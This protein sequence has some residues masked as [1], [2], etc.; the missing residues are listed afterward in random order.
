MSS[1]HSSA[2]SEADVHQL[3]EQLPLQADETLYGDLYGYLLDTEGNPQAPCLLLLSLEGVRMA[4]S[5]TP[6]WIP[7]A[8]IEG[9]A[10]DTGLLKLVLPDDNVLFIGCETH[11]P[12]M[13]FAS[14]LLQA[15]RYHY[16]EA[17]AAL[18]HEA[19]ALMALG[20]VP[21]AATTFIRAAQADGFNGTPHLFAFLMNTHLGLGGLAA[22][23]LVEATLN[24]P[25]GILQ[26]LI[27]LW[28]LARFSK[29]HLLRME[30]SLGLDG[31]VDQ[32][33][34]PQLLLAALIAQRR[35]GSHA[36]LPLLQRALTLL[37]GDPISSLTVLEFG[38]TILPL[39]CLPELGTLSLKHL[40]D[41]RAI[42][43]DDETR[44]QLGLLAA[45][46]RQCLAP[47]YDVSAVAQ[48]SIELGAV[49]DSSAIMQECHRAL[50]QWHPIAEEP[51]RPFSTDKSQ[52][53]TLDLQTLATIFDWAASTYSLRRD[54]ERAW[55]CLRLDNMARLREV[56][57]P[58]PSAW[59]RHVVQAY[60]PQVRDVWLAALSASEVLLRQQ[61][62]QQALQLLEHAYQTS[63]SAM[64]DSPD[65]YAANAS[66]LYGLYSA[67]ARRDAARC[68]LYAQ[69][70]Q[71]RPGF[72]WTT[73]L[74]ARLFPDALVPM[75]LD[76][77]DPHQM[78][79]SFGAWLAGAMKAHGLEGERSLLQMLRQL[80]AAQISK[81]LRVCIAGETSSGKSSFINALLGVPVL[82]ATQEEATAVPTHLIHGANWTARALGPNDQEIDVL[83]LGPQPNTADWPTFQA[84][85]QRYSFLGAVQTQPLKR[86]V[87]TAPARGLWEGVE[88]IDTPG[89]NAHAAR[90]SIAKEAIEAA[91]A[92]LFLIDARNA[93]KRGEMN[94]ITWA[95]GA[96]G[97]TIFVVNKMD[98][99]L[100]DD[101]L[102]CESDAAGE[103][104]ARIR[105]DLV[106][107]LGVEELHLFAVSSL[108]PQQLQLRGDEAVRFGLAIG[109][110]RVRLREILSG[111]YQRLIA[112]VA[113]KAAIQAATVAEQ[114]ALREVRAREI[115]L[116]RL[117]DQLPEDEAS[118]RKHVFMRLQ[119]TWT[120]ARSA[121]IDRMNAIL[122]QASENANQAF[123]SGLQG[124]SDR[125]Q[126]KAFV[127]YQVRGILNDFL[128]EVE[129]HRAV[130]WD[131]MGRAVLDE[132]ASYFRALYAELAFEVH[133]DASRFMRMAAPL[134]LV[135]NTS[136]LQAI[137]NALVSQAN[138][139]EMGAAAIGAAIGTI[140]A[141]GVGT[142]V[143][144]FLGGMFGASKSQEAI[145]R[146][147]DSIWA[148]FEEVYQLLCQALS[149]DVDAGEK[150]P[151]LFTALADLIDQERTK[152]EVL[153]QTRLRQL[154]AERA[155]AA[156]EAETS[157][158]L[159]VEAAE[160]SARFE[161]TLQVNNVRAPRKQ[162]E[163]VAR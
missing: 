70:L 21:Q 82:Y 148:Q 25:L 42:A 38:A 156:V 51:P 47:D 9:L 19:I 89:F 125:E 115:Q 23:N 101:D 68:R 124:C 121:Y 73:H 120:I 147:H 140:I 130:E 34:A 159:A 145:Q 142:A 30:E 102:D 26:S 69:L 160:W 81:T 88:Y 33:A 131:R 54:A 32:L 28:P 48:S 92:C 119:D 139:K 153:I 77:S 20:K 15:R 162:H 144:A 106:R 96:V 1:Y 78:A 58:D 50:E 126:I 45:H 2:S 40:A 76:A 64:G 46:Y 84:F 53:A 104:L 55:A 27:Q 136:E 57:G 56:M 151:L 16:S 44:D 59:H 103:L 132:V 60:H 43:P 11:E 52:V 93:L 80:R 18:M 86:L 35:V 107:E 116:G 100:G 141:P 129:R 75:R 149:A 152:F 157:R 110:V 37:D 161:A 87:I 133:F 63:A 17:A 83:D 7:L 94:Q 31:P 112:E 105:T 72:R 111:S 79:N 135:E 67:I 3:L 155:K 22:D 122:A 14:Q 29:A 146:V 154:N 123:V 95:S 114:V 41:S 138:G 8:D 24:G 91:H 143:G 4:T 12:V 108:A 66:E 39:S 137:V 150:E 71:A 128:T 10:I 5:D 13:D 36:A 109:E 62:P 61:Q 65:P 134:P 6:Y 49:L 74:I 117:A 85:V 118:F 127:Q 97:K 113:R 158:Q 90:T 99:V 163:G 98:A